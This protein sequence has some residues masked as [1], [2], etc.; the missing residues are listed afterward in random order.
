MWRFVSG[1]KL[2][3]HASRFGTEIVKYTDAS[4]IREKVSAAATQAL[5][6]RMTE[7]SRLPL[8]ATETRRLRV[9]EGSGEFLRYRAGRNYNQRIEV[10]HIGTRPSLASIQRISV[11]ATRNRLVP[12]PEV[13]ERLNR[14]RLG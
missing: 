10:A 6:E 1:W 9:P 3:S 11:T 8:N 12:A 13:V 14:V 5:V 4:A 7:R 2:S